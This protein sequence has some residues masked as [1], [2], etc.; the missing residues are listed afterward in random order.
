MTWFG[1]FKKETD[2]SDL[3]G[4]AHLFLGEVRNGKSEAEA[5]RAVGASE[6]QVRLWK[7]HPGFRAA[8]KRAKTEEPGVGFFD[9]DAYDEPVPGTAKHPWMRREPGRPA[10]APD[11][12]EV[13]LAALSA[14]QRAVLDRE[15]ARSSEIPLQGWGGWR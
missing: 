13:A 4:E 11:E 3:V 5:A 14:S 15:L 8:V 1:L 6:E 9:L 12:R 10:H 7:R 2:L